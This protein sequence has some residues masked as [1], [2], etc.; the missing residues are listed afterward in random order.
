[1]INYEI[2]TGHF[3]AHRCLFGCNSMVVFLKNNFSHSVRACMRMRFKKKMSHQ[4]LP[5]ESS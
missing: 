2:M 1:M 3:T 5:A 4:C